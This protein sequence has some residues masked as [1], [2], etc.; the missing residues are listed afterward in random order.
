M[1]ALLGHAVAL[2][3]NGWPVFPLA[4]RSKVPLIPTSAGGHGHLDGST[5]PAE[6]ERIWK[7][8]P[9]ANIGARVPDTLV[10]VDLDPRNG[11]VETMTGLVERY[12]LLPAT[13]TSLTGSGG[14]HLFYARPPGELTQRSNLLGAGIDVKVGGRG[15]VVLPPSIHPNGRRYSWA[16]D[17]TEVAPMPAWMVQK[18]RPPTPRPKRKA[19]TVT[20]DGDSFEAIADAFNARARWADILEPHGW[21]HWRT[22]GENQHWTRPGENARTSAT[23]NQDGDGVLYVFSTAAGLDD[24]RA[25]SKFGAFTILNYGGDYTAAIAALKAS[26]CTA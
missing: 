17:M 5:D 23:I 10:C 9:Y 3:A 1:T 6:A 24:N 14:A 2:A 16:A 15:Y 7:R 19:S 12:G 26:S 13:L 8:H 4:R 11:A 18:L 21:T 22:R 25:Y 20:V